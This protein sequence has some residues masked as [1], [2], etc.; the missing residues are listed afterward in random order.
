MAKNSK[1]NLL[2][3]TLFLMVLLSS[4][5]CAILIP[6]AH[7]TEPTTPEKGLSILSNTA[8]LDMSEYA[9]TTKVYPQNYN[10][11]YLGVVAQENVEYELTAEGSKVKTLCTFANSRLQVIHVL[12]NEGSPHLSKTAASSLE[13]AQDFL[14]NY[15]AYTEDSFYG[16]LKSTLDNVDVGKNSTKTEG[17]T[18]LE[19]I[20][21]S[22]YTTFKWTYTS[23][24]AIA[25]AKFVS[26]GFNNSFLTY[27]VDNWQLYPIGSTTVNLSERE[28]I[29]IAL[30]A[31]KAHQWSL[32]LE[33]DAL[34]AAN[35][36]ESSVCWANL[37]FDGSLYADQ[38]RNEDALMLYPVWRVGIALNKWYGNMYGI[39]V[40]I[41][42]DTKE[43]RIVEEAW[44][45][46]TQTE[47]TPTANITTV[48]K[49]VTEEPATA[50]AMPNLNIWLA[51]ATIAIATIG[52]TSLWVRR[53]KLPSYNLPKLRSLKNAGTLLCILILSIV[54]SAP[55]V[56]VSATTRAGVIWGSESIGAGI[57]QANYRKNT[58]EVEL[59]NSMASTIASYFSQAGYTGYDRQGD[60]GSLKT[61]ILSD[62]QTYQSTYDC[63]AV[64]DFDHGVGRTDYNLAPNEFHYLFE[65]NNGTVGGTYDYQYAQPEN[66]VYDMDIYSNVTAS[67]IVFAF[68]NT[69]MSANTSDTQY[70]QYGQNC[71]ATQ[72]IIPG[73]N[74]ARGMPYAW[75]HRLVKDKNT[76]P[77]F[78]IAD[79]ISDDGYT[80]PD[81][82]SQCYIGFPWGSASLMQHVPYDGGESQY[83]HQWVDRFFDYALRY[84]MS[85][86]VALDHASLLTW[87]LS[88][89]DC[90]LQTGFPAYWWKPAGNCWSDPICTMAVYGNGNVKLRYYTPGWN[91][92]F[93]DNSMDTA[94]WEE[95]EVNGALASEAGSQLSVYAPGSVEEIWAQA[96]Y[97]TKNTYNVKDCK[98]TIDVSNF[99]SLDEM[100]L[101]ICLTNT[102]NSDPIYENN[103]YRILKARYDTKVY[104]Q[105]KID[106]GAVN[107]RAVV[108]WAGATGNLSIDICDGAI[109]FY[110]NGNM[111][112]AEPYALSS[113]DCYIYAFA[114]TLRSRSNGTD[115]L[116]NFVLA[117]TPSFWDYFDDTDTYYGWDTT[118]G[119]W[120]VTGGKLQ[121]I[122][123][124]S[125]IF[126]NQTFATNIYVKTDIETTYHVGDTWNVPWLYVKTQDANNRIYA[127]IKI[128]GIVE[129]SIIKN[130]EQNSTQFQSFDP[131]LDPWA[132]NVLSVSI[133]GTNAKV[134]VNGKLYIDITND[135]LA[136][137]SGYVGLYTPLSK[138]EFDNVVIM[139]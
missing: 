25:P 10:S 23:N 116:D 108:D 15:Q 129:L 139:D 54:L 38:T 93:N 55:I 103:W 76:Y 32:E 94:K 124:G 65:D 123:P 56:T 45:T 98:I 4:S 92:N 131:T 18:Q 35:F 60:P 3:I 28:A 34:D 113:Y 49:A 9:V 50:E 14:T 109:A 99:D 115:Y 43:V 71:T 128:G 37:I 17:N 5:A 110:E 42:A 51:L 63:V 105:S 6:S 70:D 33:A 7:A 121:A 135:D 102:T 82:G 127:L 30:D 88:F 57:G 66:G 87:G 86:N 8:E 47:G 2:C 19:V 118:S 48:S 77:G 1:R 59:Q 41:W 21:D 73:T 138:G 80:D 72:G 68:I 136:T 61:N 137:I 58:T 104:V 114:S 101:Q 96:G 31:A 24:G 36:N 97:V 90:V 16:E 20:A 107:N 13:L 126:V 44:S 119:T 12:E 53:K 29:A 117:P 52:T 111:R 120:Q 125:H 134:W 81:S 130:G 78:N 100:I 75:T 40:D 85:V 95:L 133:I 62:L 46:M 112:Y 67:K 27:F 89:G 11:S 74:R 22:G 122:D 64:V 39:T 91:D 26:L 79:H 69:C 106:G 84:D 83:Y 132:V